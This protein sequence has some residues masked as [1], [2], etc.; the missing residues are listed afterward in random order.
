MRIALIKCLCGKSSGLIGHQ[1][2]NARDHLC[3]T[4]KADIAVLVDKVSSIVLVA[5]DGIG[6]PLVI[7]A[8]ICRG[9]EVGPKLIRNR[10]PWA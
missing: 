6:R 9:K 8:G 10:Q 4:N 3:I 5:Q 1:I 2:L 7:D